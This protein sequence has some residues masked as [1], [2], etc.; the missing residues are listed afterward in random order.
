MQSH[1][2][3]GCVGRNW[4]HGFRYKYILANHVQ[5]ISHMGLR[6]QVCSIYRCHCHH[7]KPS[8]GNTSERFD[9][10]STFGGPLSGALESRR[11]CLLKR[12][13]RQVVAWSTQGTR[14]L[15]PL[16]GLLHPRDRL[17]IENRLGRSTSCRNPSDFI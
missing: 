3:V 11:L 10:G 5:A 13:S 9:S 16:R 1:K 6:R 7:G 17:N 15:E 14:P 2:H 4:F 8:L 12:R